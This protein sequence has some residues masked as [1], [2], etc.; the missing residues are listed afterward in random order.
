[1]PTP[2]IESAKE[3]IAPIVLMPGDPNRA[4]YIAKNFL[5]NWKQ[6][7]QVRGMNAYTGYYKNQKITIFPSG[8]GNPSIGIYSYELFKEYDVKVILRIGTIGAYQEDL[9]LGDILLAS[10][11]VSTSSYAKVQSG[12][13][14][15]EISSSPE[16]NDII[17]KIAKEQNIPL[18]VA[19]VLCSDV[20]YEE[21][22]NYQKQQEKYHIAG[23]EMETFA[24]F[25]T[26]NILNKK[27]TALL[28]VSNSFC[29]LEELSSE[30][31]E[32]NLN[33]MI[34]LA[35]ESSLKL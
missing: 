19:K 7:N 13:E 21:N 6:V 22:L 32:K 24:L 12:L 14:I 1:M 15:Q 20:F 31:R 33:S 9:Q 30:E 29:S 28:T 16:I 5:Q 8:M 25:H 18:K 10:T 4:G 27:A 11:S 2:H 23:V 26:A 3:D 34:K 17:I 35:L